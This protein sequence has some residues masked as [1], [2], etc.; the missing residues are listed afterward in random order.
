MI[1]IVLIVLGILYAIGYV[2]F[3]GAALFDR[4][5]PKRFKVVSTLI[6]IS[7]AWPIVLIMYVLSD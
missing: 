5:V 2:V 4:E 7:L 3:L 6:L 1:E